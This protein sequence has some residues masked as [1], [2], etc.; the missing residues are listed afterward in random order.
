MD[1]PVCK[2]G[3]C[4]R[5]HDG[6][7]IKGKPVAQG[8][9][10]PWS[11]SVKYCTVAKVYR[12]KNVLFCESFSS[13]EEEKPLGTV[14]LWAFILCK[15][16]VKPIRKNCESAANHFA[17]APTIILNVNIS[18]LLMIFRAKRASP[19]EKICRILSMNFVFES[20]V[21]AGVKNNLTH[22]QGR[23]CNSSKG[24]GTITNFARVTWIISY[25]CSIFCTDRL[26]FM[27]WDI[28]PNGVSN[29]GKDSVI[30]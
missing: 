22:P 1:Y 15:S 18:L 11:F 14:E 13:I 12:C 6:H 30:P 19:C 17:Q 29:A 5:A 27:W 26:V 4:Y 23:R 28:P 3:E 8:F 2:D 16:K 9:V 10:S 20:L 7:M 21:A 24:R 25:R